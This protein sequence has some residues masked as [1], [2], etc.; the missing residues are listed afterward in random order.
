MKKILILFGLLLSINTA[1]SQ[2]ENFDTMLQKI[3]AEK[4]DNTRIDL[5]NDFFLSITKQ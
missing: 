2:S 3:A 4:D 5:I 1:F